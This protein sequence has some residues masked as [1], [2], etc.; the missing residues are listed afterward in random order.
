[1]RKT[2]WRNLNHRIT[3]HIKES[4]DSKNTLCG[5]RIFYGTTKGLGILCT[6]GLDIQSTTIC[7]ICDKI[8]T[9]LLNEEK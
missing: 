3:V 4:E 5:R 8:R 7:K 6:F 2:K 1:M 9:N